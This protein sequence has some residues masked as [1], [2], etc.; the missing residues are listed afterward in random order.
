MCVCCE[1]SAARHH[2]VNPDDR[3]PIGGHVHCTV[4]RT[5]YLD[6]YCRSG[7]CCRHHRRAIAWVFSS[8]ALRQIDPRTVTSVTAHRIAGKLVARSSRRVYL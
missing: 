2:P 3:P 4:G 1:A 6:A 7:R 8:C 5:F